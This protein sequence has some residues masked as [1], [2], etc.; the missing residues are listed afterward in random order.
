MKTDLQIRRIYIIDDDPG[1]VG[2]NT[3]QLVQQKFPDVQVETLFKHQDFIQWIEQ[4][5]EDTLNNDDIILS[6]YNFKNWHNPETDSVYQDIHD[7]ADLV[8]EIHENNPNVSNIIYSAQTNHSA[9]KTFDVG[10]IPENTIYLGRENTDKLEAILSGLIAGLPVEAVRHY[11]SEF[12]MH[13]TNMFFMHENGHEINELCSIAL[14]EGMIQ[15]KFD[16]QRTAQIGPFA[17]SFSDNIDEE[18]NVIFLDKN[19]YLSFFIGEEKDNGYDSYKTIAIKLNSLEL[20]FYEYSKISSIKTLVTNHKK[21]DPLEQ[22]FIAAFY[23]KSLVRGILKN[24]QVD[25]LKNPIDSFAPLNKLSISFK[26]MLLENILETF[27][28]LKLDK[29]VIQSS[30]ENWNSQIGLRLYDVLELELTEIDEETETAKCRG[31]SI[32][33]SADKKFYYLPMNLLHKF[34]CGQPYSRFRFLIFDN[35]TGI[36]THAIHPQF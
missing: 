26:L 15:K 5:N 34:G 20:A 8:L 9:F 3:Q 13:E 24:E 22:H 30:L 14:I 1:M 35:G 28:T 16:P 21:L 18:D 2:E 29:D 7:G 36:G 25:L 12:S 33:F 17:A 31:N 10:R 23:P 27:K 6:D 4:M 11:Q 19:L 32:A